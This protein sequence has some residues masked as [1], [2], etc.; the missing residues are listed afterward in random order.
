[1]TR[2]ISVRAGTKQ[3]AK[4]TISLFYYIAQEVWRFA[5]QLSGGSPER[6]LVVLYYHGIPLVHRPNF[7][8][9][10]ESLQRRARVWPACHRGSL[11]SDKPNVAITFDDAYVSVAH[12]ALP[13]LASRGFHSTIFVP[14][15][16]LGSP[17]TWQMEPGSPDFQETIMSA[18][19]IAK[20]PSPLVT[21]G[22][23]SCSHP[24]LSQLA[25]SDARTEIQGSRVKLQNL[26]TRDV[27]LFAFPYGDHD[28]GTVELCR[29]A[30]YDYV[31]TTMPTPIDAASSAFVRGRVKV[32]PF[33]G[34]LEYFLK[35]NGAYAWVSRA[36]SLK[37]KLRKR[38]RSR[39]THRNRLVESH[40]IR[41]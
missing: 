36:S 21:V 37:R 18:E 20:L 40:K 41:A 31:F 13:E 6:K 15:G 17:P 7:V 12:N 14:V 5:L 19:Q 3:F 8:R 35:Y 10:M 25:P 30:G 38:D 29:E 1:M 16:P 9:Q 24:R 22:S 4:L 28:A 23:H 11:P 2:H 34:R 26:T 32:D 33:D 27:R 39:A